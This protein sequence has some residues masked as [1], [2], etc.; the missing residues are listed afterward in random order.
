[1][2]LSLTTL[3][4]LLDSWDCTAISTI[5]WDFYHTSILLKQ[6]IMMF[7][8]K[9]PGIKKKIKKRLNVLEYFYNILKTNLSVEVS[10]DLIRVNVFL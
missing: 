3:P 5:H 7:C 2:H 8:Q 1:M 6:V 9:T 4:Y 10:S